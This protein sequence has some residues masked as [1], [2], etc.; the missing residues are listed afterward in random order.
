M[1]YASLASAAAILVVLAISSYIVMQTPY[2]NPDGTPDNAPIRAVGIFFLIS[3]VLFVAVAALTFAGAVLLLHLK[4]LRPL[5]L[6]SMVTI[7]SIGLAFLM[8]LDR[9]FGWRDA[10]YYFVGF[11]GLNLATLGL[12]ALVWWRVAMR[13]N[14]T[15]ER[16]APQVAR[17]SL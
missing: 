11:A 9:P 14:H 15:V 2:Q 5:V 13:P 3:P 10:L 7:L 12:S 6:A 16:D 17:P 8:V 1:F 4:Q